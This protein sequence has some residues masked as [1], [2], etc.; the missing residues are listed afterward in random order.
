MEDEYRFFI[1]VF[2]IMAAV[3]AFGVFMEPRCTAGRTE[4]YIKCLEHHPPA[5]CNDL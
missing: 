4:V 3:F 1:R 2:G 5:E